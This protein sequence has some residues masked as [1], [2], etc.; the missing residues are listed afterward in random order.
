MLNLKTVNTKNFSLNNMKINDLI[1]YDIEVYNNYFLLCYTSISSSDEKI[2]NTKEDLDIKYIDSRD[3]NFAEK[4]YK[5]FYLKVTD[6]KMFIGYN[7]SRYDNYVI[8]YIMKN[9]TKAKEDKNKFLQDLKRVSDDIIL[10]NK[11]LNDVFVNFSSVDVMQELKLT[12][13]S[14][15]DIE[16]RLCL[17]IEIEDSETFDN[18]V[19]DSDIDRIINYCMHDVFTT[20]ILCMM[21]F[22]N[23][24]NNVANIYNKLYL[25][26][27]Y[28]SNVIDREH[29]TFN[30]F[31]YKRLLYQTT[32]SSSDLSSKYFAK[33]DTTEKFIDIN[34][35]I[36]IV[37]PMTRL[38]HEI[39]EKRKKDLF[40]K[41]DD[42]EISKKLIKFGSGGLH[43]T[44]NEEL[45]YYENVYN[46]DV[47]SYYPS[48]LEIYLENIANI[49]LQKYIKTKYDRIE[50]KK[51]KDNDSKS[52]QNAYKL[53]L[54]SLTGKFNQ[55]SEYNVFYNPSVYFSMTNSC[56]LLLLD[57]C[58]RLE[59]YVNLVQLNT[60]GIAFTIKENASLSDK[61][62][63]IKNI[64]NWEKDYKFQLEKS[65]FDRFYERS[66]NDYIAIQDNIKKSKSKSKGSTFKA[67]YTY[68][69]CSMSATSNILHKA[70]LRSKNNDFEDITRNVF[71]V[72]DDLVDNNKYDELQFNL[73]A[74]ASEKDK[75]IRDTQE[76]EVFKRSK[77]TRVFLTENAKCYTSKFK[78]DSKMLNENNKTVKNTVSLTFDLF[79]KD[80]S[81]CTLKLSK[82]KYIILAIFEM[83]KM[84][85]NYKHLKEYNELINYLKKVDYEH[86][87]DF[88][89]ISKIIK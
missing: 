16:L 21:S 85:N 57:L 61:K 17:D 1:V 71:K 6:F 12:N 19:K 37:E 44:N 24:Y 41:I 49:D 62:Q 58:E 87:Y 14:L 72:V 66:V 39:Y 7:N 25:Y 46:Y 67:R 89:S 55:M 59:K 53:A 11:R 13:S 9:R 75:Y 8:A 23:D 84:Y 56:Q 18:D 35:N 4:I 64:K 60:D 76:N 86:K 20:S 43:T 40:C 36:I 2:I 63:I 47:T 77:A 65:R 22:D 5:L 26:D 74:T 31:A 82:E 32:M 50:L 79:Q 3:E 27:L 51:K 69:I 29:I 81:K 34:K 33:A 80:L 30:D 45:C 54:N 48:F 10:K 68:A 88:D 42:F 28:M 70:Y 15:K 83:S 73:K 78:F 52:K 38:A